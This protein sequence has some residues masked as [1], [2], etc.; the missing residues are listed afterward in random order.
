MRRTGRSKKRKKNP[1]VQAGSFVEFCGTA[2]HSGV[3]AFDQAVGTTF[4]N[5][6]AIQVIRAISGDAVTIQV[7]GA[8]SSNAVAIQVIRTVSS[9]A[10]AIQMIRTVSSN[11]I[12]IQ[13]IRTVS[14]NAV[15]VQVIRAISSHTILDQAIGT[16]LGHTAFNQ[17]IR[18]AFSD[19]RLSRSCGKSVNCENRESNAKDGLAFHDG[20][21]RGAYW[22]G[23]EQ[24]L[25]RGFFKRTS[26]NQW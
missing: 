5:T 12:A 17:T 3:A 2:M 19:Y 24:M 11:A 20:V 7:I 26:L 15:A 23:M 22:V 13:V 10:V 4:G 6:I 18:A 8:V 9:N 1:A 14:G 25:R 21:L 16:T